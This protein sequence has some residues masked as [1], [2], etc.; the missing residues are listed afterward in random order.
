MTSTDAE[1]KI[2][3]HMGAI[4]KSAIERL[5]AATLRKDLGSRYT[6]ADVREVVEIVLSN[7]PYTQTPGTFE[8]PLE[9][10]ILS[11]VTAEVCRCL[12][13]D[14]LI[15]PT[16]ADLRR[17]REFER[18]GESMVAEQAARARSQAHCP[19]CRCKLG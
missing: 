11:K 12:G 10:A 19:G 1:T 15:P 5:A 3:A 2:L 16:A 13:K 9:G 18:L 4:I 7:P 17:K 8:P 6:E 14:K